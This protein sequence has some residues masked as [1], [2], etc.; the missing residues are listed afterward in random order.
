VAGC[1]FA[2]PNPALQ[3]LRDAGYRDTWPAVHGAA[4]GF[5]GMLNRAGC[6]VPEGYPFKRI[7]Y[8]WLQG[9]VP[10]A[11]VRFGMT[12][13]GDG[14]PSDHAGVLATISDGETPPADPR[15]VV[16]YAAAASTI[17]GAWTL[18][19]DLSAAAGRRL[20]NPDAGAAKAA[21]PADYFEMTFVA[22]AGIQYHL[23]MRERAERDFYGNDSV[24][25][26]FSDSIT[27][28]GAA[29]DRI[30]STSATPVILE[31]G[32]DAVISG[33]G[34][35]DNGYGVGV[36]GPDLYFAQS[37]THT[38]RVQRRED[39]VAIDQIVLSA[40]RFLHVAPGAVRNDA[41]IL[42]R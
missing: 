1:G 7:D 35:Q 26:Q 41:T 32:T 14:T 15:E 34:W 21:A 13:P 4:E 19:S 39:G 20:H 10:T 23:W 38:S 3:L 33:W 6:G 17:A 11:M 24:S 25:V 29:T 2:P 40:G 36:M 8:V 27:A 9:Y 12:T 28:G 30:G 31:D 5:T 18:E 16:L 42:P 22:L 37:G